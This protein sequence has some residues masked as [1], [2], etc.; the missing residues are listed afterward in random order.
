MSLGDEVPRIHRVNCPCKICDLEYTEASLLLAK[1][2]ED[3]HTEPNLCPR[4][5][6][7]LDPI[8]GHSC[9]LPH[10]VP[11]EREQKYE[12]FHRWCTHPEHQVKMT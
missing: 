7:P 4:Y 12:Q 1:M 2:P 3:E 9:D 10:F 8:V 6:Y 5:G 11:T